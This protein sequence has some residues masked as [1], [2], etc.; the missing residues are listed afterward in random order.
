MP[1]YV[2][3]P[4]W[5]WR[6]RRWCHLTADSTGELHEFA[7]RLGLRKAWFQ[8]KPGRPWHDHYDI[9][10]DARELAVGL[11]AVSLTTREMGTRQARRRREAL[12]TR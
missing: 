2:D 12:A 1:V 4:I 3:E 6:G 8:S 7:A 5:A 9:P 11:G 10:G